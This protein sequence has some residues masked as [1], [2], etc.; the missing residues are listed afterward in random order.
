[1]KSIN[2]YFKKALREKWALGQFNFSTLEQLKGIITAAIEMKSPIILGTSEKESNFIGLKQAVFLVE[3][4]KKSFN[5]PFF[6]NLDHG[7]S[8]Q[9]IKKA[10]DF[11]YDAVHFD[12]SNLSIDE[13]I[14][15]TKKVV[16]Y[17]LKKRVFVEGEIGIIPTD[18][19]KVYQRKLAIKEEYLTKPYEASLFLQSTNVNSLAVSIGTFHGIQT[20]GK[21]PKINLERL[22]KIKKRVGKNFLALHGGSGTS[23]TDLKKA[24]KIG[25]VK[26]NINTDLRI[27]YTKNLRKELEKNPEEIAPYKYLP[28][29]IIAVKE[30]V[31]EK[32]KL[33]SSANKI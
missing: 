19:S 23:S 10:I 14:K 8:Y 12:G 27:S 29:A 22:E 21:N 13:N 17:A 1:M 2:F 16:K 4:Y 6:L 9:Y 31:K 25:I 30:K 20:D 18:S 11:G 3:S 24:I 28:A 7:K 26:I 33:F 32:I 5:A 15:I